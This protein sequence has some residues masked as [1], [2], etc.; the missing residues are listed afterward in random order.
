M[1]W[2]MINSTFRI[3]RYGC[4]LPKFKSLL[5][6]TRLLVYICRAM[7]RYNKNLKLTTASTEKPQQI[8]QKSDPES[9]VEQVKAQLIYI[10]KKSHSLCKDLI[11]HYLLILDDW[12]QPACSEFYNQVVTITISLSFSTFQ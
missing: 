1:T 6:E 5:L 10:N 8:N 7:Y 11:K 2:S 3:E 12:P 9:P 4:K